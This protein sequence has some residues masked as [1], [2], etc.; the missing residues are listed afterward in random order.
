MQPWR[1]LPAELPFS[2]HKKARPAH[3]LCTGEVAAGVVVSRWPMS[4]RQQDA[5]SSRT[6][7]WVVVV[8]EMFRGT[9]RFFPPQ[10]CVNG[11]L[12]PNAPPHVRP[13]LL[14]KAEWSEVSGASL[15]C[16]CPFLLRSAH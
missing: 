13:G 5:R 1:D 8:A 4:L 11:G 7:V 3:V 15:R 9:D 16:I 12:D 10:E 6:E 2:K 14:L